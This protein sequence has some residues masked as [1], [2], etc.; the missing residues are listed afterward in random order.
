MFIVSRAQSTVEM[1]TAAAWYERLDRPT[2]DGL[3]LDYAML[4][5]GTWSMTGVV[6][7][8]HKHKEGFSFA[9]EGFVTPEH[10]MFYSGF[11]GF[12]LLLFGATYLRRTR[13]QLSWS[14]AVPPGYELGVLG[15]VL[16]WLGAPGDA[17]WHSLYGAEGGIEALVSPT[18]LLLAGGGALMIASPIRSA[19]RREV[20][21]TWR[22]CLPMVS[23]VGGVLIFPVSFT[24]YAH[25]SIVEA[26]TEASEGAV[27]I[28]LG[29]FIIHATIVAAV[30]VSIARR[31]D[32]P[33][34]SFAFILVIV[35]GAMAV[36]DGTALTA[37]PYLAA[38]IVAD[39]LAFGLDAPEPSRPPLRLF[40]VAVPVTWAA[41]Y[42][43]VLST[44]GTIAW[45]VHV[46]TGAIALSGIAGLAISYVAV[47]SVHGLEPEGSTHAG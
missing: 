47:P 4:A 20:A 7:D 10:S 3:G 39:G 29:S 42:F 23:S 1:A 9:E 45:T 25:P 46:W 14:A 6:L 13:R 43:A 22:E 5:I 38:G 33:I 8:I 27:A 21:P 11:I 36:L 31:F 34:G 32:L 44:T 18:H 16:F 35:G 17:T 15:V 30:L 2:L 26:G 12:V 19:W 41:T 24:M 37:L 28:G 40:G